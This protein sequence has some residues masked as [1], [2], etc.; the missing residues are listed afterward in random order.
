M[1]KVLNSI[2]IVL[3]IYTLIPAIACT[4]GAIITACLSMWLDC[5]VLTCF[6]I[7]LAAAFRF[8]LKLCKK[9]TM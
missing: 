9:Q 1:N 7:V 8:V 5:M 4:V 2:S 6:A 3:F